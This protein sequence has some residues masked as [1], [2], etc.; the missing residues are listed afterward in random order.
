MDKVH[1]SRDFGFN[2]HAYK[3]SRIGRYPELYESSTHNKPNIFSIRVVFFQLCLG[4]PNGL[5]PSRFVIKMLYLFIFPH[6]CYMLLPLSL[7]PSLS[8]LHWLYHNVIQY[9][10]C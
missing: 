1:K 6:A 7:F 3:I 9:Y 4:I 2:C 5:L 10:E 8:P